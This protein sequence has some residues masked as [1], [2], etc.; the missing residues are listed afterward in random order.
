MTAIAA[1]ETATAHLNSDGYMLITVVALAQIFGG[2]GPK[3]NPQGV[4]VERHYRSESGHDG[5]HRA[6]AHSTL[7]GQ[8]HSNHP[9]P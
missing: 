9:C 7:I 8:A 2:S 4:S 5:H 3:A 6:R 1:K